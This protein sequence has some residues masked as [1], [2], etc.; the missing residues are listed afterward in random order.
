MAVMSHLIVKRSS[1]STGFPARSSKLNVLEL[2]GDAMIVQVEV[3][4]VAVVSMAA[5]G[6]LEVQGD[7]IIVSAFLAAIG[8][9]S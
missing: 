6:E 2:D 7:A 1:M 3:V 4:L 9:T 5:M 8:S